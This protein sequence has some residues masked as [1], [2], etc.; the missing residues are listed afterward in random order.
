M[1]PMGTISGLP[2]SSQKIGA[3]TI[4]QGKNANITEK[5]RVEQERLKKSRKS[6]VRLI[7][8]DTGKQG[9]KLP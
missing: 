5:E 7:K 9:E 1:L 8:Q 2:S 3:L 6:V 4:T